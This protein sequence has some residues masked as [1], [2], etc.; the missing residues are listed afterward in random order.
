MENGYMQYIDVS[1]FFPQIYLFRSFLS[2]Q[3]L[4]IIFFCI[5]FIEWK[6]SKE[7]N[8]LKEMC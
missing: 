8:V 6:C 2:I 1:N 4:C 3:F 7:I 5:R